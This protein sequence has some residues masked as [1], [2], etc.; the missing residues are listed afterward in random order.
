M[1]A[2]P[3]SVSTPRQLV[4]ALL[5]GFFLQAC[6]GRGQNLAQ[7]P[8]FEDGTT[9]GWFPFGA[10]I[11]AQSATAHSGAYAGLVQGRTETWN[12]IAQ[13]VAAVIQPGQLYDLSVW[14]RLA[15]AGTETM[16]LTLKQVDGNGTGYS[17][18]AAGTV[19]YGSWAQLSGQC[20]L[21]V[22]GT[23]AELTLYVEVP[24]SSTAAF[25]VDDLAISAA[26]FGSP[27]VDGQSILDWE[28]VHQRIDGFGASSAWRSQWTSTQA[29]MF[30]STN[31]GT[32]LAR[33]GST[34]PFSGIGLSLL[35]TRIAPGA[36]TVEQSIMQ[37]A[38]ARGARVWS[39]PWSPQTTF[40][41]ANAS[42]VLSVNGGGFNGTPAN[43]Q[44][45]A[46][47][48]AGYVAAMKSSYGVDLYALSVQNEP[49]F[50][51]TNYESCVWTG[52]QIH[53]FVPYLS[54]ALTASN[55][56]ATRIMI[57]ESENWNAS[58]LYTTAMNDA[59][60]APLVGIIANHNYVAD[61][62]VGDQA[63][64]AALPTYGKALWETEVAKL[65]GDDSSINDGLYWAGR[66][67]RFLTGPE[68]N[69]WHYWWLIAYGSG[70]G[71]LCDTNDVPAKR[72]YALGN[73]SRFV[74]P[75]FFRIG[76]ATT[77][78][79]WVSSYRE[80]TNR[81]FAVVAINAS[82]NAVTQT[83]YLTNAAAGSVV[84]WITS[85]SSSLTAQ[86]AVSLTNGAFSYLLP[87]ESVVTFAGQAAPSNSPPALA[88]IPDRTVNAGANLL[89]TN[90][91]MDADA[92]QTLTYSLLSAPSNATLNA[93]NGIFAW[94]PLVSQANTT[95]LITAMVAD[96][97]TPSLSATN[98]YTLVVDPLAPAS[99]GSPNLTG[100]M[101]TLRVGGALGPDYTL[102]T[103]TNLTDWQLLFTT[104]L[105]VMPATLVDTN[106][107]DAL[108][109]YRLQLGP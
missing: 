64:P 7:N 26:G 87:R 1:L 94:R 95:N 2:R 11:S 57:P 31:C 30:F 107:A 52:Q 6:V 60:V 84:P 104:N 93:T 42:G 67:H 91:A 17:M 65:S 59:S 43:Y 48:L 10:T 13:S 32:G 58:S 5:V 23:L 37:M 102:L 45:Y 3:L 54:A 98:R 38:Q 71:G 12:G 49:D 41:T 66:V 22:S 83:F 53:D 29:D 72:M 50:N 56:G 86:P 25:Y 103:S 74:R 85:A 99:L 92:A 62:S 14:V 9:S 75:G 106:C 34:F 33:N 80:L 24:T 76:T 35:R 15:A 28:E 109:F 81:Q 78:S 4:K 40:K 51:T 82:T 27:G 68:A 73:F 55:V 39:A 19:S 18:I 36:T 69:A 61:N 79:T 20:T 70:N 90:T 63:P 8:G 101:V 105:P 100:G 21:S 89:I 44:A 96:D 16:Q 97:G 108:R 46:N 88:F 77:G 47:Q